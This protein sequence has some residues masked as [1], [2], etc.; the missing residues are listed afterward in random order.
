MIIVTTKKK[1]RYIIALTG[2]LIFIP[3]FTIFLLAN[4]HNP[5]DIVVDPGHGGID[6]GAA[7]KGVLEKE[8]NLNVSKK[9]K[10]YLEAK[11]Y[12]VLLTRE[13][14]MSLDKFG[15]AGQSRHSRDLNAR[16]NIINNSGTE[17]F[18]SIHMNYSIK[19]PQADA[20][21]YCIMIKFR[22]VRF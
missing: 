15:A 7:K 18:L 21:M 16:V 12:K 20:H 13:S 4:N 22:K 14:D 10:T 6:G 17:I 9:L 19:N 2:C 8:I 5:A 1:I 3:L 11:G